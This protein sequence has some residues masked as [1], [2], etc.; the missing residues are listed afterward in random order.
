MNP[1][2]LRVDSGRRLL[3]AMAGAAP[4]AAFA[5]EQKGESP[6]ARGAGLPPQGTTLALA[7]FA[8]SLKAQDLPGNVRD[9]FLLYVLDNVASLLAGCVQPVHRR[10]QGALAASQGKGSTQA[11]GG[12]ATSLSFAVMLDALALGDFEFEHVMAGTHPSSTAFPALLALAARDDLP[13][14]DLLASMVAAYEIAARIGTASGPEVEE[15]RGLHNPGLNGTLAAAA[16]CARLLGLDAAQCDS[17]MGL[18][19]SSSAGLMAFLDGGAVTKRLHPARCAQLGMESALMAAAGVDGPR[20]VLESEHGF[21]HAFSPNPRPAVLTE[22]LG[23]QWRGLLMI[24]KLIPAHAR[25]Q[26][27]IEAINRARDRGETWRAGDI[28]SVTAQAPASLLPERNLEAR[29]GTLVS[30]Q[31]SILYCI[32][33]ALARD[34]RNPMQMNEGA[35]TDADVRR[36]AGLVRALPGTG[37]QDESILTIALAGRSL[38]LRFS[39]HAGIP[40]SPQFAQGVERKFVAVLAGLGIERHKA[41][42]R[43]AVASV[44][45][46]HGPARLR[47]ALVAAGRDVAGRWVET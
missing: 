15:H 13:G 33:V 27:W 24:A 44:G 32:A 36:I 38:E 7:R 9:T 30:A 1:N 11:V 4:F 12:P 8:T 10:V 5:A 22:R 2:T 37:T 43:N 39:G 19:A 42:L 16:G 31:Y 29:P 17:A 47:K 25:A 35:V 14:Q 18:A 45:E 28:V 26:A 20:G 41:A 21:L 34:L 23:E 46:R 3:V 40:G 6:P